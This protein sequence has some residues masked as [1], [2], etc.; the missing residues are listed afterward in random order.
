MS[1]K[2]ILVQHED[3]WRV[4]TLL[5]QYRY[6]GRWRVL[7]RYTTTPG[8]TFLQARWADECRAIDEENCPK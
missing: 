2:R 4:A 3:C 6:D 8:F 7:V 5:R 1:S